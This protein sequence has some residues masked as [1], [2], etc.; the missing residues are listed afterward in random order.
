MRKATKLAMRNVTIAP[1]D[2]YGC[3]GA[4]EEDRMPPEREVEVRE[5]EADETSDDE[6]E[7]GSDIRH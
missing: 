2:R 5:L 1:N 4:V 7:D 3:Y 6:Q